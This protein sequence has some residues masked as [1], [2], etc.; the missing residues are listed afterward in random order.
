MTNYYSKTN[1][2]HEI[3]KFI[4]PGL[5][6]KEKKIIIWGA[7]PLYIMFLVGAT[8]PTVFFI[9]VVLSTLSQY[10]V[11]GVGQTVTLVNYISFVLSTSI[12]V[13]LMFCM[14][15]VAG[16]LTYM[17]VLNSIVL[18]KYRKHYIVASMVF[19]AVVTPGPDILSLIML[20]T[21]EY[22]S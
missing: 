13:G 6:P 4:S 9:T 5:Y 3:Y 12:T 2:S 18:Q 21:L 8:V 7:A 15:N 11:L 17:G 14:P 10:Y 20:E 1:T 19:S 16:I 22:S